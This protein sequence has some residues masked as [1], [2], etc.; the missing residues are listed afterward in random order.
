MSK[1]TVHIIYCCP[2]SNMHG[3]TWKLA[4]D[5]SAGRFG[6]K[7]QLAVPMKGHA[8]NRSTQMTQYRCIFHCHLKCH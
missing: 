6:Q 2:A 8:G 4:V 3:M 1:D 7:G 5:Q